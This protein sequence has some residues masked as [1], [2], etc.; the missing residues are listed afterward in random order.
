VLKLCF[1]SIPTGRVQ[2]EFYVAQALRRAGF[3]TPAAFELVQI[4]ERHGIVF[5]RIEGD[6]ILRK[7]ELKPWLL[8][9]SAR[10]LAE[11]HAQL[12][13]LPAPPDLPPQR[14]QIAR[15]LG[16]TKNVP[17]EEMEKAHRLL[18]QLPAGDS[19]CHGDFHP[20]NI[21]MTETGPSIVDWSTGSRGLALA[22]VARTSVLFETASLPD[23]SPWHT[24]LLMKVAR[25][26]LHRT[27][28][29]RYFQL[30][31]G[32]FEELEKW[33]GLQRVAGAGLR[34]L[35]QAQQVA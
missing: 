13:A 4:G 33:R 21:I 6:S 18:A 23:E 2:G 35:R 19:L 22:D 3:P 14:E 27:Y 25:R 24:H 9:W 34:T 7:V 15:W 26:L 16:Y 32:R 30:R 17:P 29:K 10:Q 5:E 31:P 1:A 12:H 20:A 8:F 11:L 28:L